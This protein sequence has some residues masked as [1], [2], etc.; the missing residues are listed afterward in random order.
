MSTPIRVC[1]IWR[2]AK[3]HSRIPALKAV[4]E[5]NVCY[6]AFTMHPCLHDNKC[7]EGVTP[8][9]LIPV[10]VEIPLVAK[11]LGITSGAASTASPKTGTSRRKG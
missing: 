3:D 8:E 6:G 9:N 10:L 2:A 5:D 11:L 1:S 4:L 7:V